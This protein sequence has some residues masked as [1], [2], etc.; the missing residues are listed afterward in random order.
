MADRFDTIV[1]GAGHNGLVTAA[2]LARAGQRV[3]VL[4]RR[5]L[6]GGTCVTEEIWPGYKVSTAAYVNSLLR[7]EIIRDLDL[8]RHGFA[9]LP[10]DPSSFT[11]FPDG[12]YLL[13]GPDPE[14]NRREVSKFSA[15]DADAL[16]RYEKMLERVTEL[17]EPTLLQTPPDP[18]SGR[19]ADLWQLGKLAWRFRK[20]GKEGAQA[21]DILTG[22]ARSILDRWFE[23]EQLKVTLATDA[24][25]G[26]F[27]SPSMPG[28][29]YVLFH[30]VM[31]E[32]EGVRGVWGYVRGGMGGITQA[33]AAA[34]RQHGADIRCN[35][36]VGR[37]LVRDRQVSGVALV[38][39][40]EFTAPRVASNADANVT[41]FKLMD[42][43]DLPP[44]FVES[45]RGID[46]NSPALKINVALGEPPDFKALPGNQ[47]G[48]HHRGTMHV[49]PSFDYMEHA[50]DDAKYGRPSA[51]PLL[52][53][54]MASAVDPIIA[55]AGKHL[56][57]MFV[58]YAPTHLR[59]GN[60]DDLK[61]KF[62]DRCFEVMDD[63][64]PNFSRS[65]IDRQVL[66]PL[67]LERRFNL[68]GGNIFHGAMTLGNLF[69]L[70]PAAGYANYRT[71][72]KGLYLCGAAAHPGGGVMGA[73]GYNAAR[74][75]LRDR[76]L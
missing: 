63:Y 26:A 27:A 54:T 50:Y 35:A 64:A 66:S 24:V 46:Y 2:Y 25:I 5:E 1:I 14:L 55:P 69:F 58:Q 32:C 3:L 20:L 60:W 15:K 75:I 73:C 42:P 7:P 71:P 38:D 51:S 10:R 72:I 21:I 68:T 47:V 30:H 59:E 11:P 29:A 65:V 34:A 37:I 31:G 76:K 17:I 40:T 44:E 70:R 53:C 13:M 16:P 6:V 4:E 52:E 36:T 33:L 62:A 57:S 43:G 23:S 28:T 18:W 61:D 41:F 9:M 12:R 22:A 74:E 19:L 56:M 39:G 45:I 48:P 8:K 49:G 67:D